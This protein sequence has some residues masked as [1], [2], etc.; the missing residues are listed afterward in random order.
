MG[1]YIAAPLKENEARY[2][3]LITRVQANLPEDDPLFPR[4]EGV[5]FDNHCDRD[6]D[7]MAS[8]CSRDTGTLSCG[9]A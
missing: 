4:Y 1:Y 3:E 7:C 8:G 2:K 5:G 9:P 6:A